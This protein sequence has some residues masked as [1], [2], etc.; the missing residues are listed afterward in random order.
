MLPEA[1][2]EQGLTMMALAPTICPG[3]VGMPYPA[4][5]LGLPD[6]S[7]AV[8]TDPLPCIGISCHQIADFIGSKEPTF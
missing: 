2:E 7:A 3:V 1:H 4:Q 5:Y 8:I 6:S